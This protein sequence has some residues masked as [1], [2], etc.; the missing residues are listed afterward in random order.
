MNDIETIEIYHS[1]DLVEGGCNACPT[2]KSDMYT[3]RLNDVTRPLSELDVSSLMMTVA[4]AKGFKQ[5][6]QYD[7]AEDYD[8]YKKD[9]VS[10]SVFEEYPHLVVEKDK[11][12]VKV[13][14]HPT[15]VNEVLAQTS[16]ILSDFFELEPIT[17]EMCEVK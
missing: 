14:N 11:Q 15:D 12:R 17:F 9:A 8:V 13:M 4:L 6:Q 2:V 5:H 16:S 7:M 3:I 1:Y 10:V